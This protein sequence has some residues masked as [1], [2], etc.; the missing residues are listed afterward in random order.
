M[1]KVKSI[2]EKAELEKSA[3]GSSSH[4]SYLCPS[5]PEPSGGLETFTHLEKGS[6]WSWGG[7]T[8]AV[9]RA[10]KVTWKSKAM[11][12]SIGERTSSRRNTKRVFMWNAKNQHSQDYRRKLLGASRYSFS[13]PSHCCILSEITGPRNFFLEKHQHKSS[14]LITHSQIQT[15]DYPNERSINLNWFVPYLLSLFSLSLFS[16][17]LL[18]TDEYWFL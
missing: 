12:V 17:I 14:V 6:I 3:W 7:R 15:D 10:Q 2:R 1:N 16:S 4:Y 18:R 9:Y 13:K 5:I 8:V 11:D